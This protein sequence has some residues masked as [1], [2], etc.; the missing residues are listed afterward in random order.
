[1][2]KRTV[3]TR[4]DGYYVNGNGPWQS[5]KAAELLSRG[6]NSH[7]CRIEGISKRYSDSELD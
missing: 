4:S 3:E 7:A 1:M 2:S 5:E 6:Y